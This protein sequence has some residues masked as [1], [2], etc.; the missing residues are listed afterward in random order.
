MGRLRHEAGLNSGCQSTDVS[1]RFLGFF[2]SGCNGLRWKLEHLCFLTLQQVSQ[3]HHSSVGKFQRIMMRSRVVRSDLPKGGRRVFD[4]YHPPSEQTAWA[5]PYRS[6][7]GKLC[8]R[9][10]TNRRIDIFRRS[11][12]DCTSMEVLGSQ[13]LAHLNRTG[14]Y[15][16]AH[17][18]RSSCS[19]QRNP[20]NE[21]L[22]DKAFGSRLVGLG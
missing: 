6:R 14:L 2:F 21:E 8:S 22:L 12:S 9:K 5:A 20:T 4:Y 15:V 18:G 11:K 1:K 7:E 17:A 3:Q 19:S 13:F 10:N 16:I